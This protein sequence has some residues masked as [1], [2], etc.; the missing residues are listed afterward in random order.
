MRPDD[1]EKLICIM[2]PGEHHPV[3]KLCTPALYC[4]YRSGRSPCGKSS[5]R[6]PKS[7]RR[8]AFHVHFQFHVPNSGRKK[9][10]HGSYAQELLLL[11]TIKSGNLDALEYFCRLI[12]AA[13]GIPPFQA[14]IRSEQAIY[15]FYHRHY[16]HDYPF[17]AVEG[18]LDE[19]LAFN[20]CEVYVQK[21]DHCK[22]SFRGLLH[23][24]IRPRRTLPLA[25]G[26]PVS[27]S[28]IP[29]T[30]S[31]VPIIFSA[32]CMNRSREALS[33]ETGLSPAI[34]RF[35]LKKETGMPLADF[36]RSTCG[37]GKNL[38]RFSDYQISEISSFLAFS[39]QSYFTSV[40]KRHT[41]MTQKVPQ[42]FPQKLVLKQPP[43]LTN[44]GQKNASFGV[45]PAVKMRY[46]KRRHSFKHL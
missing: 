46:K 10:G 40:F 45:L 13:G 39:S 23:C 24:S 17:F 8:T 14:T 4:F 32:T 20:M 11:N 36:I 9:S 16:P 26:I 22:T 43:H 21:V 41:G 34:F 37:G 44:Q 19:E 31:A 5:N 2:P 30:L 1:L 27:K 33:R 42:S 7:I 28:A 29:I 38:L 18:G 15:S 3:R 25:F 12:S 35:C 6:V